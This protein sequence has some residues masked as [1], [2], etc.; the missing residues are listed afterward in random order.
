MDML[1]GYGSGSDDES[2]AQDVA[3]KDVGSAAAQQLPVRPTA[4]QE[5]QQKRHKGE[6]VQPAPRVQLPSASM[7]LDGPGAAPRCV[8]A[9]S[10]AIAGWC[11]W[12][13]TSRQQGTPAD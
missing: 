7:L 11:E 10:A 4:Q 1:A 5:Q 2:D 8:R 6:Q 9:A 3:Q 13:V 12:C